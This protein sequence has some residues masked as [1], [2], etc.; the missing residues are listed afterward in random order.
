M[1]VSRGVGSGGGGGG[2]QTD[3]RIERQGRFSKIVLLTTRQCF[4]HFKVEQ[5]QV[6]TFACC[7]HVVPDKVQVIVEKLDWAESVPSL[8]LASNVPTVRKAAKVPKQTLQIA[9]AI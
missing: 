7:S 3:R 1:S 9:V 4:L 8:M 5:K 2:G 6:A